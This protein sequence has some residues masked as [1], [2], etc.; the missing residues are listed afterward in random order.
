MAAEVL[1][2]V[3]LAVTVGVVL[4]R[5]YP[6]TTLRW[7][8]RIR[9]ARA[10]IFGVFSLAVAFAF[11]SSGSLLLMSVGGLMLLY[12]VVWVLVDDVTDTILEAIPI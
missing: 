1:L 3:G 7:F 9:T 2:V 11:I 8:N 10:L 5:R 4:L 12:G 6:D